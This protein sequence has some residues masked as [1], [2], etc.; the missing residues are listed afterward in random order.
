MN[1][2]KI[3]IIDSFSLNT[4]DIAILISLCN[5]I[6]KK[7]PSSSISMEVSHPNVFKKSNRFRNIRIFPR[8]IDIQY[9]YTQRRRSYL[10]KIL[11]LDI[12]DFLSFTIWALLSFF[13]FDAIRIIRLSRRAQAVA[14]KSADIIIS[15]G[16]GFLSTYYMYGLRL[17][18]LSLA[19]MLKKKVVLLSQSIGPFN[20]TLSRI[21]IPLFLNKVSIISVREPGSY[22]YLKRMKIKT[23]LYETSDLAFLLPYKIRS[24][25]NRKKIIVCIKN[26]KGE[27]HKEYKEAIIKITE[28]LLSQRYKIIILS[29][30]VNDD[31][32]GKEIKDSFKDNVDFVKFTPSVFNTMDLYSKCDFVISSRMHGIIFAILSRVPFISIGDEPKFSGLLEQIEYSKELSINADNIKAK[33]LLASVDFL[34]KNHFQ[35]RRDITNKRAMLIKQAKQN[36]NILEKLI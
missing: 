26:Y 28:K 16:G 9:I 35:I 11:L 19:F 3:F 36:I 1:K 24:V 27:V 8:I 18:T 25:K 5:L 22:R 21:L 6:K 10:L 34:T 23:H 7:F 20:T 13:D 32:L 33:K 31:V 14:L 29:Q 17:Y 4:G 2:K 30:T 15:T 12:Y